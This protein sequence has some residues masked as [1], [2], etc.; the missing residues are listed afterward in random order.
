MSFSQ[1]EINDIVL[2]KIQTSP[3]TSTGNTITTESPGTSSY[4]I[5]Q[6]NIYA[7]P[8]P[9]IA[10][11]V[12]LDGNIGDYEGGS[13]YIGDGDY[14][15][16]IKYDK[17]ELKK[18]VDTSSWKSYYYKGTDTANVISTNILADAIPSNQD[19]GGTYG[20]VIWNGN[21]A[22]T[23]NFFFDTASGYV[24][25]ATSVSFTPTIT[26][27]RYE[28]NK[29]INVNNIEGS[30]E[31]T[32][33]NNSLIINPNNHNNGVDIEVFQADDS[34]TKKF[35]CLNP[36]GG[37]VGIGTATPYGKLD[38]GYSAETHGGSVVINNLG[39]SLN[40]IHP[41]RTSTT[42]V[43]DPKCCLFLGR[44][45]TGGQSNPCGVF[46]KVCRSYNSGADSLS[47]LDIDVQTG[48][49]S[50]ANVMKIRQN[51]VNVSGEVT[52]SSF[53]ATSDLRLKENIKPL[54]NSLNKICSLEGVEFK[55]KNNENKNKMIGFIAQ[56]V[57]KIVPEVVNTANDEDKYK[58]IAYGNITALLVE[59]IKE[60]R[61][62]VNELRSQI[63][64]L[65]K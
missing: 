25:F 14:N 12:T 33:N 54:E 16:I 37:N 9:A 38:I 60:L 45:G 18:T 8:I 42:N 17:V 23:G 34:S 43:D 19:P 56:E 1:A 44:Q 49:N 24:T 20:I 36:Y 41:T 52:A 53:N 51:S 10:P 7:S 35:L 13:R 11:T 55:F 28:G 3:F 46:F 64:T 59:A 4:K 32:S 62:E 61:Q 27:W 48:W 15:Y 58:S 31:V 5:Q 22:Y 30:L 40:I 29:G 63:E 47:R 65:K 57:E 50:T 6:S 2:K 26:F 39:D 21:N